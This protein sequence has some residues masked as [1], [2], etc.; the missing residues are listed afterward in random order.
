M[1][2]DYGKRRT[3][4]AVSDPL[5]IIA[6]GLDTVDTSKLLDYIKNYMQK[7]DVERIVV[8]M[9]SQTNGMPSENAAR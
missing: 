4:I 6:G 5:Q 2:I 9:P 3:G 1:A 8:G 7:E